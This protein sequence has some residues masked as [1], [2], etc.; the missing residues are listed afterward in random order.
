MYRK[1]GECSL[2]HT[3]VLVISNTVN[4]MQKKSI[5]YIFLHVY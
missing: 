2:S 1:D 3:N 5:K 4:E